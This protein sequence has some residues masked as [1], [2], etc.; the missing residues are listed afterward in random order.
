[1]EWQPDD[2]L[3]WF[4]WRLRTIL[5]NTDMIKLAPIIAPLLDYLATMDD[6]ALSGRYLDE[7]RVYFAW[8]RTVYLDYQKQVKDHRKTNEQ[9]H[10]KDTAHTGGESDMGE[11]FAPPLFISPALCEAN[12][13]T[14][15]SQMMAYY[16]DHTTKRGE[17]RRVAVYEPI[18]ITSER[19]RMIPKNPPI[20]APSGEITWLDKTANIALEG[21]F[22]DAPSNRWSYPSIVQFLN[23]E[24]IAPTAWTMYA[25]LM[26]NL[27][28][29]VY[30]AD[31][32]SYVIDVLWAMGTYFHQ[33]WNAFP[34]LALHG[35]KGAG[36]STLLT[37]LGS[38]CFNARFLVNTSEAALYRSIQS[39]APTLLI[40]EQEGLNN[41]KE[42]KT[43]KVDMMGLLKTGYKRGAKVARQRIDRPEITEYFELYSPKALAAIELF[44]DVLEN[45][46]ILTIM[47]M[48][49]DH[50]QLDEADTIPDREASEFIP[51]RDG[52]YL[53]LMQEAATIRKI[54]ERVQFAATN[55]FRELFKPLYVMACFVDMSRGDGKDTVTSLL[56][57][58]AKAKAVLRKD[59]DDLTPDAML[60]EALRIVITNAVDDPEDMVNATKL[61]SGLIRADELQIKN[62]FESLF[63]DTRHSF[64]NG[65]WLGKQA[66]K[67]EG[68]TKDTPPRR[69]RE[70]KERD[71]QTN[72][73]EVRVKQIAVYLLNPALFKS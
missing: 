14:Y 36:K 56:D 58:A 11:S 1:M 31:Q 17:K 9:S 37:W 4:R 63:S 39:H 5:P 44:E 32:T 48:K 72:D 69:R 33:L 64:F 55:R 23:G 18:L 51:L 54:T 10:E 8:S 16:K 45:R 20:D 67:I 47:N 57:H 65:H 22:Y 66:T 26:E 41:S 30:H 61:S 59:R 68:M 13:V 50:I 2:T 15:I 12:G 43:T 52:L 53:L 70:V 27:K 34:Y 42:A 71:L 3:T 60:N 24:S 25:E 19:R 35:H 40:D 7:M 73:I 28:R 29:Y 38:V 49:P 46:A 62:A 21:G 6:P